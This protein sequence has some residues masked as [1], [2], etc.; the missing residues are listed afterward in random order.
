MAPPK[1]PPL[2]PWKLIRQKKETVIT[3]EAQGMRMLPYSLT[4]TS[5]GLPVSPMENRMF[6][7][8]PHSPA[9]KAT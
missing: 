5:L 8:K 4:Y 9:P 1:P 2:P 6:G 7:G 3:D